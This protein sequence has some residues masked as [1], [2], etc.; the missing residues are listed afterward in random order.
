MAVNRKTINFLPEI[1]RTDT[2]KKFLGSTLD[3]LI[4]EPEL[5]KINGFVGR[6]FSPSIR[7]DVGFI[8]ES[9]KQRQD[10]QFE[11]SVVIK[12]TQD[13]I[14]TVISYPD[15]VD[16][17]N[18]YGAVTTD[19]NRLFNSEYYNFDPHIDLD[20]FVNYSNY[21]WNKL[22]I[23]PTIQ[24]RSFKPI[25]TSKIDLSR[26]GNVY[27]SSVSTSSNPPLYLARGK[28]YTLSVTHTAGQGNLWLQTEP[29]MSGTVIYNTDLSVRN[30]LGVA[31]N[32]VST[33]NVTITVPNLN[34]QED[35]LAYPFT[36]VDLAITQTFTS[37]DNSAYTTGYYPDN[38]LVIFINSTTVSSNWVNRNGVTLTT[39]ERYGVWLSRVVNDGTATP[40]VQYTF[41]RNLSANTR[42]RIDSGINQGEEYLRTA[43]G[44]VTGT[45]I[46]A[47]LNKIYYQND[48]TDIRGEIFFVR[49]VPGIHVIND[50]IGELSY[51]SPSGVE[52]LNGM[53]ITF[54]SYVEPE[55]YREASFYV[56][57][58]GKGI[59]LIPAESM[60]VEFQRQ[61]VDGDGVVS[62]PED[63][64]TINRASRDFNGWS[65][66]NRW[67][68]NS[69]VERIKQEYPDLV[70]SDARE[71]ILFPKARRPI[72]EF[73]PDLQLFQHGRGFYTTVDHFFSQDVLLSVGGTLVPM[74]EAATQIRGRSYYELNI[75]LPDYEIIP[76]STVIFQSDDNPAV[77]KKIYRFGYQDQTGATTFRSTVVGKVT[78]YV[79]SPQLLGL[80]PT[81]ATTFGTDVGVGDSIFLNNGTLL[82][83]VVNILDVNN[84]ILDRP[85]TVA[86]NGLNDLKVNYGLI[87]LIEIDT[88][89]PYRSVFV[90]GGPNY[91]GINAGSDF[92][93][94]SFFNIDPVTSYVDIFYEWQRAQTKTQPNQE[95]LFDI[96]LD[97]NAVFLGSTPVTIR[98]VSLGTRMFDV[99]GV[100]ST[101]ESKTYSESTFS[102]TKI[103][104]YVH[105]SSTPDEVLG[106][107]LS[108]G[109]AAG[110]VGDINFINNYDTDTFTYKTFINGNQTLVTENI[111]TG[112]IRK[113]TGFGDTDCIKLNVWSSVG[114]NEPK[115]LVGTRVSNTVNTS[116]SAKLL[117]NEI[118]II[119]NVY[120]GRYPTQTELDTAVL[121]NLVNYIN[122]GTYALAVLES[123]IKNSNEAKS[124]NPYNYVLDFTNQLQHRSHVY[125]GYTSYFELGVKPRPESLLADVE[126][127]IKVFINNKYVTS[128]SPNA[129]IWSYQTF[130]ARHAIVVD[131][132]YLEPGD[133]I[134]ILFSGPTDSS[135]Y[136]QIP[137]NL[138]YNYDN[139]DVTY[140]THGQMRG[141]YE[142]VAQNIRALV[143][144]PLGKNNLNRFD[145]NNRG[146][147]ILQ[148]SAPLTYCAAFLVDEQAN[149]MSSID[150]ARREYTRFKNKLLEI[151]SNDPNAS[152]DNIPATLDRA[153]QTIN[154]DKNLN[155]FGFYY[156]DMLA[157]G[158][159]GDQMVITV[160][161]PA[162]VVYDLV[163]LTS[164]EVR[165]YLVYHNTTLLYNND[166]C[167]VN[168]NFLELKPHVK[169]AVDDKIVVRIY[170][171]TSGSYIPETP[172]K[173]GMY[174]RYQPAKIIDDTQGIGGGYVIQGH[175][176]SLTPAFNDIRDHIL[177]EF[178]K[179]I[180][181]NIK[182]EY[183]PEIF[184]IYSIIPG[185][186]RQ[187]EYTLT[188][189]NQVVNSEFLKWIGFNHL[190]YAANDEYD[191]DNS[192]TFNYS[193]CKNEQG[194]TLP[195]HWRGIFK[196]YYDTDRPHTHPWEM[197]GHTIKPQ[198]WDS[199]YSWTEP[200]KRAALIN[201]ISR[202]IVKDPSTNSMPVPWFRRPGFEKLVP[203]DLSGNIISP[204]DLM[205][206]EFDSTAFG[207]NFVIGDHGPAETAWRRSSEFAY[208]LVRAMALLKPARF[209]AQNIDHYR[210]SRFAIGDV[211]Q[212]AYAETRRRPAMR[213]FKINGEVDGDTII[214]AV[215]YLNWIHA[216]LVNLGV[217]PIKKLR[218]ILDRTQ[219]NLVHKLGGFSDKKYLNVFAEQ[220][221]PS[222]A[223]ES[224]LIPD[225]NFSIHLN[226]SVPVDR[227]VYS[228]VIIERSGDGFTVT[229]YDQRY[230]YFTII[231]SEIAGKSYTIEALDKRA[232]VFT[233]F[234]PEKIIIPYGYEFSS[235]Q[236][237]VD[238]LVGY[239]RYLVAQG[240][241]FDIYD[242]ILAVARDWILSAREFLTW[243]A[244][245]WKTGNILI[246]SPVIDRVNIQ[247]N[248][249][250]V[251]EI[252]NQ[253]YQSRLLG[254]NFNSIRPSDF[255]V[256][257][258][259]QRTTISTVSGQTI[260]LVDVNFVEFEH[261]LVFDNKTMFEDTI[262]NPVLGNRQYKMRLTG[263]KTDNWDGTLTPPGF[264]YT[265]AAADMWV[266]NKIYNKG[267]IVTYK[268]KLYSAIQKIDPA[269]IF[270]LNYWKEL[271]TIVE[272]GIVPN[273]AQ[274]AS[275]GKDIYDVDALPLDEEFIK[276]SNSLIG[277]RSRSNLTD[278]GLNE[279][280]QIKFYQGYIKDKGTY[281]AIDGLARGNFDN[282]DNDIEIYEEWGARIGVFGGIDA[283]P[284]IT[285][286]MTESVIK[287][288][289]LIFEFLGFGNKP[290]YEEI[291]AI[292]PNQLY[293]RPYDYD[294]KIFLNRNEQNINAAEDKNRLVKIEIFG[295][296]IMC[297]QKPSD[298]VAYTISAVEDFSYS[299]E[300]VGESSYMMRT[301][302]E[303][304]ALVFD[305][306]TIGSKLTFDIGSLL[307][308]EEVEYEIISADGSESQLSISSLVDT[309]IDTLVTGQPFKIVITS[310]LPVEQ[311]SIDIEIPQ[312][313]DALMTNAV[314]SRLVKD[315]AAAINNAEKRVL[316]FSVTGIDNTETLFYS[317]EDAGDPDDPLS[318]TFVDY[319]TACVPYPTELY[320]SD[321]L[322]TNSLSKLNLQINRVDEPPS[323]LI[324]QALNQDVNMAITTRS[325]G[326]SSSFDILFGDGANGRWPDS[327]DADIVI[328]NHG[329]Y[330]A[331]NNTDITNYKQN[332]T[333][334]RLSLPR[335]IKIIWVLPTATNNDLTNENSVPDPRVEWNR[336]NRLQLYIN[337]MR[338]VA[339]ANGDYIADTTKLMNWNKYLNIDPIF[340]DQDGYRALVEEVLAPTIKN[341]IRDKNLSTQITYEDDVIS[342][343]Y[344]LENEVNEIVFDATKFTI[345][346]ADEDKYT[347]GYKIWFAKDFNE[348]WQVYRLF[349]NIGRITGI[350]PDLSDRYSFVFDHNHSLNVDDLIFVKY[351]NDLFNGIHRIIA[352]TDRTVIV[353][354][355]AE[356]T[357]FLQFNTR[358]FAGAYLDFQPL[359][360]ETH[361]ELRD[362]KPKHGWLNND[363]VFLDDNGLGHWE[364]LRP[365]IVSYAN[366]ESV[367][368]TVSYDSQYQIL[369][370]ECGNQE[371]D[372]IDVFTVAD[373]RDEVKFS[374]TSVNDEEDLYWTIEE[375]D[376]EEEVEIQIDKFFYLYL[377][378][379][380][381]TDELAYYKN[382]VLDNKTVTIE[383]LEE[384][385]KNSTE[386]K[387]LGARANFNLGNV[388]TVTSEV[389]VTVVPRYRFHRVRKQTKIVDIDSAN[390]FYIFSH[391]Q[392]RI[393]TRLDLYDPAKGRI[394]GTALQDLD[395]TISAD[396]AMYNKYSPEN[397]EIGFDDHSFWGPEKLG[398]YWWNL[399]N[400]RFVNYEHGDLIYRS[401]NW[402]RLFPG[403]QVEVYEW[404]ESDNIPSVHV[405]LGLDGVPLYPDDS[406]YCEKVVIDLS[407]SGFKSKYYFWVRSSS[408]KRNKNKRHST[409]GLEEVIR[410]PIAQNIPFLVALKDNAV[411]LYNVGQFLNGSDS[412]VYIS[413]KRKITEN[414]VHSNFALVQEGNPK[415]ALPAYLEEKI[416][417]SLAA[418]DRYENAVPDPTL[419][420]MRRYGIEAFPRQSVIINQLKARENIVK[421]VNSVLLRYPLANRIYNLISS[422]ADN[423]YAKQ[424][425]KK[426][427]Y[428]VSVSSFEDLSTIVPSNGTRVYVF[429]DR[430]LGGYW[431]I[432]ETRLIIKG[433]VSPSIPDYNFSDRYAFIKSVSRGTSPTVYDYYGYV[434]LRRQS[435][436]VAKF[437][438][439]VQWYA[440][441]ITN[442]TVPNYVLNTSADLLKHE[443][444]PGDIVKILNTESYFDSTVNF[445]FDIEITP[446]NT[447]LYRYNLSEGKLVPELIALNFGTIQLS[448]E[449]YKPLGFD[450]EKFDSRGFDYD[451][452]REF[453]YV[454]EGLKQNV[455][456]D[457]LA[458]E[459]NKVLYYTIDLILGEQKYI[460]WFFKTSFIAVNHHVNGLK[461]VPGYVQDR[462]K[463][464]AE[465]INE[466]KPYRTKI[467]EYK[468]S[469]KDMDPLQLGVTDFDVPAVW[470]PKLR[471]FRTPTGE[472]PIDQ[473]LLTQP[474]YQD[475]INNHS[476]HVDK[477][478]I[479]NGGY[480][481]FNKTDSESS[482]PIVLLR[483]QDNQTGNA[484]IVNTVI[485][486]LYKF[487]IIQA[488]VVNP[489]ENYLTAPKLE[490]FGRGGNKF[491]DNTVFRFRVVSKGGSDTNTG[492]GVGLYRI[493][494]TGSATAI[495]S[496]TSN[497]YIL[498]KIRRTDGVLVSTQQYSLETDAIQA[499]LLAFSMASTNSDHIIVLHTRGDPK[500]NRLSA[501]LTNQI[502]RCGGTSGTFTTNEFKTNSSYI[503]VGIPEC[504]ESNG[505]ENYSGFTDNSTDAYCS[506]S[507][508]LYRSRLIPIAAVPKFYSIGVQFAFPSNPANGEYFEY[509]NKAWIYNGVGWDVAK[510]PM[511]LLPTETETQAAVLVP[512]IE[513]RTVRKLKLTIKFDRVGYTS[514]VKEWQPNTGYEFNTLLSYQGRGY[515]V[516]YYMDPGDQFNFGAVT[517]ITD[518]A[519]YTNA[520]DRIMS[521]YVNKP[522]NNDIPKSLVKLVPG[523][524]AVGTY[525]SSTIVDPDTI[526]IGDTFGSNVGIS[527]GN[528]RVTG[529][530]F[531]DE[532]LTR[533]PEE[534]VPGR[535]FDTLTIKVHTSATDGFRMFKDFAN[536]I[537]GTAFSAAT[538]TTFT[539]PVLL[540]TTN[541]SVADGSKLTAP[542]VVTS[543]G[544]TVN[545][546]PGVIQVNGERIAYF[547][548]T[549]NTLEQ[550]RRGYDG[551]SVA[552]VHPAGSTVEDVST[553]RASSLYNTDYT[554][555]V[556]PATAGEIEF[557]A[558]GSYSWT[559]P[560]NVSSIS[561]VGIGG[562]GAGAVGASVNG[563]GGG[564]ALAWINGI[565]VTRNQVFTV[566]VGE[567][568]RAPGASGTAT[569]L[570]KSLTLI[571]SANGGAG[572]KSTGG[573]G[574]TF[575]VSNA[576]GSAGG[577]VGGAG[578]ASYPLAGA[579]GGGA[580]GYTGA[581]GQGGQG[582]GTIPGHLGTTGIAQAG[583]SGIGGAGG[584]GAGGN[585]NTEVAQGGGGGGVGIFG[586]GTNGNGGA[587]VTGND[588]GG[589]GGAAGSSGISGSSGTAG[590]AGSYG[591]AG[592]RFGAGGAGAALNNG[593][594]TM[595]YG[596]DGA[597]RIIWGTGRSFPSTSV[598]PLYTTT[599]TSTTSTTTKFI[600]T[601]TTIVFTPGFYYEGTTAASYVGNWSKSSNYNM[602]NV[603]G[604]GAIN[605][606][607]PDPGSYVLTIN[608]LP[609]HTEFRFSFF[610]HF[611]DSL[612]SEVSVVTLNNTVYARVAKNLG[613]AP[614]FTANLFA[615]ADFTRT[616]YSYAPY[617]NNET[618]NGYTRFDTGWVGHTANVF[619]ANVHLGHDESQ[620]NEAIY[621]SHVKLE[622]RGGVTTAAPDL[623]VPPQSFTIA[624]LTVP[625]GYALES[626]T[627]TANTTITVP[628]GVSS[629]QVTAR[630]ADGVRS[631]PTWVNGW[632]TGEPGYG[633]VFT[634][635]TSSAAIGLISP[636]L[637]SAAQTQYDLI[638]GSRTID[639]S[640]VSITHYTYDNDQLVTTT[641]TSR[642]RLKVGGIKTKSGN[643]WN[644]KFTTPVTETKIYAIEP[645]YYEEYLG[646]TNGADLTFSNYVFPGGIKGNPAP[647]IRRNIPVVTG[648]TY[649]ITV[650]SGAA[651]NVQYLRP[652]V[653]TV[654]DP[655]PLRAKVYRTPGTYSWTCPAG[656]TK[657]NIICIGA[658]G[659]GGYGANGGSG[660]GGGGVGWKNQFTVVPGNVYTVA[661][662]AGGEAPYASAGQNGGDSYFNNNS[663]VCGFGGRGGDQTV[664]GSQGGMYTGDNGGVGG[665]GGL[666]GGG[667]G[668]AASWVSNGAAGGITNTDGADGLNGAGGGGAGYN[669]TTEY[670]GGGGGGV[671]LVYSTIGGESGTVGTLESR[672]GLG[673]GGGGQNGNGYYLGGAQGGLYGGGGGGGSLGSGL[674]PFG[675]RG[676]SGAVII[677]YGLNVQNKNALFPNIT[678][679]YEE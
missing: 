84:L 439:F 167:V 97:N 290:D 626:N 101:N 338:E 88:V 459:W 514:V 483:R 632:E 598:A 513:N 106:F 187:T 463:N 300:I 425:P 73:E 432:Y 437:W 647:V 281:N 199:K 11:P 249:N 221:A 628:L 641:Y 309:E 196:L 434:L 611:V 74:V 92:Y 12:D 636:N 677:L 225:E 567:G 613:S 233:E 311:L 105:G 87:E 591:G 539:S 349:L 552:T 617:G 645:T 572:G 537:T 110:F 407:S 649:N 262:Y 605:M 442:D 488:E 583:T 321:G 24:I 373:I 485:H 404:I 589:P 470:V 136:Y 256:L 671:G 192:L 543:G 423:F 612:D 189:Y 652:L 173:L 70:T 61:I 220:F 590:A 340:P 569:Q 426:N 560:A 352:V 280:S 441:G 648:I 123:T 203:V 383:D 475:W 246:L 414:I 178:E 398:V 657:I 134:D 472:E 212:Y 620:F 392:K 158:K 79:G 566:I 85:L 58:V 124:Y 228:A 344:V 525:V 599:S 206:A 288:N 623:P 458:I 374:V 118:T 245:G 159:T 295:D 274:L 422:D 184:D 603:T 5:K 268:D 430:T 505:I 650:P 197:L 253:L 350:E 194:A 382:V 482:A 261:V 20:K 673:N 329:L 371:T 678:S 320:N 447:E 448:D 492:P 138:E 400:C 210:Y 49:D 445:L 419:P 574:G 122:S 294:N 561:V 120:L 370:M 469:H 250:Y 582:G 541:I 172:T 177:L 466:V 31:N 9:T 229:G 113:N 606:H 658:G 625:S 202:G 546:I 109:V 487:G 67:I 176:G 356:T 337:A 63:Y 630:G 446:G 390:N 633:P 271:D 668:G 161:N 452:N 15:I 453:R 140:L 386:A 270:N 579:G 331:R 265:S 521:F 586:S 126:P 8:L 416:I 165:A 503:L 266:A 523:L 519:F 347:T 238:F 43:N 397:I 365:T 75:M 216:Y 335:K 41:V 565:A 83:T 37:S 615:T 64:I 164:G 276:F 389:K 82:G 664:K 635:V 174:P 185:H 18:Y 357:R 495:W 77:R 674:S 244:Q 42:I 148:H 666:N 163:G 663:T 303:D 231:P 640:N 116:A 209:F 142:R 576:H 306:T 29:S 655:Y 659:G 226:K 507:F 217:D 91:K 656:I 215:G 305:P 529:G 54:D 516:N 242:K 99:N 324:Y 191:K 14:D 468:L 332:L 429:Y 211:T 478:E 4:S 406:A 542:T 359:R 424:V 223:A 418:V 287:R 35:Y 518:Q 135:A 171:D 51:T 538:T 499:E 93:L 130:G 114:H 207:R 600:A 275:R 405:R 354:G 455:F 496:G 575:A 166:D 502:T 585:R 501:Q 147:T 325:V 394:L 597:I 551:T 621:F 477:I 252:T 208:S 40:K 333:Q 388:A 62:A 355:T 112:F 157:H 395:Y 251:D 258:D 214:T 411:A 653:Y 631:N 201:S 117:E 369:A 150:H 341:V 314:Y 128:R 524:A 170:R 60:E 103:F 183:N 435:Y 25:Q 410:N 65:R 558:P 622:L 2:N 577:G 399:D 457:D 372:Q 618:V 334:L 307:N 644:N 143:G 481:Y 336:Q 19:H 531:V 239:Q 494:E 204:N 384:T 500:L 363:L 381:T 675:G 322:P 66:T 263:S 279:T 533:S 3:Q 665:A 449:F 493:S 298:L 278:L 293:T 323:D 661:V 141:H 255:T 353:Q 107:P 296:G 152:V 614:V 144:D 315:I 146:G 131:P 451:V 367:I 654:A 313:T 637:E 522:G 362:A 440:P 592:G 154:K 291:T 190:N 292:Y 46:T 420:T 385:I 662:G 396:P 409:A 224:V 604:F 319:G 512:I 402:G 570:I 272:S 510:S 497:G 527:A 23:T 610:M 139:Q 169:L 230:P 44:F 33:G 155:D 339:I 282:I 554:I 627:Y 80:D 624:N 240:F 302:N 254:A 555:P 476:Y 601:P 366:T 491:I 153:I 234:R 421:Y 78:G 317:I 368:N 260:A 377:N 330:D 17:L 241:V 277:Y 520:N 222:S 609:V 257:R 438:D 596:G 273:F 464:F 327:I 515:V 608:D 573:A 667:G 133:R 193:R 162:T 474:I 489:G 588:T 412:V 264:V 534:L 267:D 454:L 310:V 403:S 360:F 387:L 473:T 358:E 672:Q 68:H 235:Y 312:P 553:A 443:F 564:G 401:N 556:P 643:G 269:E 379:K 57:G 289:P 634:T 547:S 47:P 129:T 444:K 30:I 200:A 498:H 532:L 297:G 528:I 479:A 571:F 670:G 568:G 536:V 346:P 205:V 318:A 509:G 219:V 595:G 427:W 108:Y 198:W 59:K 10:Y 132:R 28:T 629:I 308:A 391:K 548:K 96:V 180:Y 484:A 679:Y 345:N 284:E 639:G 218:N 72:I 71:T 535:V 619:V 559:V 95:P 102:G 351:T 517:E 213:E 361:D 195:G 55:Q 121:N 36:T 7:S 642:I 69:V 237:V 364:V 550:I 581:G 227:A 45:S 127:N 50:I 52:F 248:E 39:D 32:G 638:P 119:Y 415:S 247:V 115:P 53:K 236:Q 378:R 431:S 530:S 179:R 471:D 562:G 286:P 413:S 188:E 456:V 460:D 48:Q 461:Q 26:N 137:Q 375:V 563:G 436:E 511:G 125:D 81:A 16:K 22:A 602:T 594:E 544:A 56:E 584:G 98:N 646:G 1:F 465:Y 490:I 462:Q 259:G 506:I 616:N 182:V 149:L 540:F 593:D 151:V 417:D 428:D 549:G 13:N 343:G 557:T 480:N 301:K 38:K 380:P 526:L 145:S 376:D 76:G 283:N 467:R 285:F 651:I 669:P 504:G 104:S 393:L 160:L 587:A 328:L 100:A 486:P 6:K 433:Q 21:H 27:T 508:D 580:G 342:A 111:N 408:L 94:D 676:G 156:S 89:S 232:T 86:V 326:G 348:E 607:G 304:N 243:C 578:G 545:V 181:N 450:S 299:V 34:A 168:G 316:K 186:F 175:D 90:T 660:G